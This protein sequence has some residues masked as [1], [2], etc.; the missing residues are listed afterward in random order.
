MKIMIIED[1]ADTCMS[2]GQVLQEDG[3]ETLCVAD[4]YLALERIRTLK[5][6]PDLFILDIAMPV[7]NGFDF[8]DHQLKSHQ[9][10][11]I[12][13]IV[14]SASHL[15]DWMRDKLGADAYLSKPISIKDLAEAIK[16]L[17]ITK[18]KR[19]GNT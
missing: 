10:C 8:R 14:F 19:M 3:H 7:M 1:D 2:L 5:F 16:K 15:S 6:K 13:V 17:K 9:L 18:P 4:G 12:P 11:H